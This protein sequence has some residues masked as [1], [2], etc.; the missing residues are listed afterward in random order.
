MDIGIL[1]ETYVGETRAPLIPFAV[2]EL[3]KAGNRVVI[4]SEAGSAS[5]FDDESY[6]EMGEIG[7]ASCRERV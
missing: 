5:G 3:V 2:G 7:R 6:R 4:Q 1:K